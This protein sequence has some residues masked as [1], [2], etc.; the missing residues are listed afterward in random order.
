MKKAPNGAFFI[1]GERERS[2]VVSAG[3]CVK[4]GGM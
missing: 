1:F 3:G 4:K 2:E